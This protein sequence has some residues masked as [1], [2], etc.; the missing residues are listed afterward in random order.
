MPNDLDEERVA[1][2]YGKLL[3]DTVRASGLKRKDLIGPAGSGR[4]STVLWR[5]LNSDEA[6]SFVSAAR[7]RARVLELRPDVTLPPPWVAVEGVDHFEWMRIGSGLLADDPEGFARLFARVRQIYEQM[8]AERA[9]LESLAEMHGE[10]RAKPHARVT[11]ARPHLVS[12]D[13]QKTSSA[14]RKLSEKKPA[15]PDDL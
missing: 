13:E 8:V 14:G 4:S 2:A 9:A 15:K 5:V 12:V 10:K 7:V 11:P 1:P 6:P 3:R